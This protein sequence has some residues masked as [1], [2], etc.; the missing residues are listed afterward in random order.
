MKKVK[1]KVRLRPIEAHFKN[2]FIRLF[3]SQKGFE[4]LN[5]NHKPFS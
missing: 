3:S 4:K 5:E 1:N 2:V